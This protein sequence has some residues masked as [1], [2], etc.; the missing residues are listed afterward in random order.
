M[1]KKSGPFCMSS[2]VNFFNSMSLKSTE[3]NTPNITVQKTPSHTKAYYP[4]V[5]KKF[6]GKKRKLEM[7]VICIQHCTSSSSM[8]AEKC[9][10]AV[11]DSCL[12]AY[13][14]S[15]LNESRYTVTSFEKIECPSPDCK[16]TFL[17]ERVI[18]NIYT[19]KQRNDWWTSVAMKTNIENKVCICTKK[20]KK[21]KIENLKLISA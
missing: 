19:A 6:K 21:K 5:A 14:D 11:C 10:H 12:R 15:A 2:L 4:N 13:F 3:T 8:K 16:A 7:C 18:R 1:N 9:E 20:K 17:S